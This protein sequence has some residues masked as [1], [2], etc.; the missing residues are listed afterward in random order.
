MDFK[1]PIFTAPLSDCEFHDY[2]INTSWMGGSLPM[3]P[4]FS[5]SQMTMDPGS[6]QSSEGVEGGGGFVATQHRPGMIRATMAPSLSLAF[7]QTQGGTFNS[8]QG[9]S[10][11]AL[12]ALGSRPG[13][14]GY[15]Q[16]TGQEGGALV[17]PAA[18]LRR[19][20]LNPR[21]AQMQVHIPSG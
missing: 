15:S 18:N 8:T 14:S 17:D 5:N 6:T 7:T 12:F 19:R 21:V 1:R 11:S 2:T 16:S 20:L 4:L 13:G 9:L 3:T 10:G